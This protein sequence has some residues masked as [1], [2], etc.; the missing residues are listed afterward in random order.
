MQNSIYESNDM[1]EKC[2]E[3]TMSTFFLK[4]YQVLFLRPKK[5]FWIFERDSNGYV[6]ILIAIPIQIQ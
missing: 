4:L 2:F 3:K 6:L 5:Y 1:V